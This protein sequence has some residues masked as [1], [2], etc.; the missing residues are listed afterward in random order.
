MDTVKSLLDFLNSY[1]LWAKLLAFSGVL[2]TAGVLIFAPRTNKSAENSDDQSS[3]TFL[4]IKGIELYPESLD[5]EI[6]VA[7]FVNGTEYQYP[8]VAGVKWLKIGRA[9]S[10]G[11]FKLPNSKIYEV[12]FE[13]NLRN[14][15]TTY[16]SSQ[17]VVLVSKLPYSD[18]YPLYGVNEQMTRSASVS[19]TVDYSI[20]KA[21]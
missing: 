11:T 15:K 7:I 10:P 19:A 12:R 6:Q 14:Y 9:M 4:T 8:S 2:L 5:A 18:D 20:E 21:P 17:R 16:L 1:P 13:A 3:E